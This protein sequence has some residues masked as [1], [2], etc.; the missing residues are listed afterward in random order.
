MAQKA[1]RRVARKQPNAIQKFF[2]ETIG[3]MKKVS[4]PTRKEATNLTMIV[5]F[6]MVIMTILLGSLDLL[7]SWLIN[8][9]LNI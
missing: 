3:E 2:R 1:Q 4:W 6:V 5:L 7:F 8:L 9:L